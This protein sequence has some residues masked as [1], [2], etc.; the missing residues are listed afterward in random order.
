VGEPPSVQCVPFV[1][2]DAPP[3]PGQVP[4]SSAAAIAASCLLELVRLEPNSP[5]A[6][7]FRTA[8]VAT[9]DA[10]TPSPY[11]ST[12]PSHPSLLL[13]QSPTWTPAGVDT[14]LIWGDYYVLEAIAWM[15]DL[16]RTDLQPWPTGTVT[17]SSSD[18][19]RPQGPIDGS[20]PTRWSAFGDGQWLQLDLGPVN[21]G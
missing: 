7:T 11:L 14:S 13:Q 5:A 15:R 9:I 17:A 4:D 12:N 6:S 18:T 3:G 2:L 1:D 21:D 16:P 19:N 20:L 8:A 10:L